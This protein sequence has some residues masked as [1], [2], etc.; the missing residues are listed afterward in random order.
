[1]LFPRASQFDLMILEVFSNQHGSMIPCF[2]SSPPHLFPCEDGFGDAIQMG[3]KK[4]FTTA[5]LCF[6]RGDSGSPWYEK[7]L[8]GT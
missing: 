5:E 1:M 3:K 8:A 4:T 2:L 7:Q 6:C